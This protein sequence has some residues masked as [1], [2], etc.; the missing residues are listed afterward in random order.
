M[1]GEIGRCAERTNTGFQLVTALLNKCILASL[2]AILL[3]QLS[4]GAR[5]LEPMSVVSCAEHLAAL[6]FLSRKVEW[7]ELAK[8][9]ANQFTERM[10]THMHFKD[11]RR[12]KSPAAPPHGCNPEA[13]AAKNS[14]K[15]VVRQVA[16]ASDSNTQA[17]QSTTVIPLIRAAS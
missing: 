5:R 12:L 3:K 2:L 14:V 1:A 4:L 17:A 11:G 7:Q 8:S 10:V 6:I 9:I 13:S 16:T 15:V